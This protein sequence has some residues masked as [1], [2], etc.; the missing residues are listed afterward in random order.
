MGEHIER[1]REG[2]FKK[3]RKEVRLIGDFFTSP[4]PHERR[5]QGLPEKRGEIERDRGEESETCRQ[6]EESIEVKR[7]N[8]EQRQSD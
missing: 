2:K 4:V 8:G 6:T 7:G 5:S 3:R 1:Q